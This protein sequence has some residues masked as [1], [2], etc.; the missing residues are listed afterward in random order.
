M[1]KNKNLHNAK[2]VKQ[3]EFYTQLS[4]IEKEMNSYIDYNPN[5]FKNKTILLPC[6]SPDT[7]NFTKFFI[8][9]FIELGIK[10]L[11]STS[12][13]PKSNIDKQINQQENILSNDKNDNTNYPNRGKVLILDKNNIHNDTKINI[14]NFSWNYL[15]GDGDFRS[16][17]VTSFRNN[18]DMVIT[19]PPFSL[20]REFVTWLIEGTVEFSIIGTMNAI[21][22][23][24]VFPLIRENKMWLGLSGIKSVTYEVPIIG[25]CEKPQFERNGKRYQSL[26]NTCWFSNICHGGINEPLQLMTMSENLQHNKQI[27]KNLNSYKKYDNY[28]AIEVPVVSGIPSDYDGVMGVPISFMDK[29][30]PEQFEIIGIAKRGAG[31]IS[32]RTRTYTKQDYKNYSDLNAGPVI[33]VDDI[34]KSIYPRILI[35]HKRDS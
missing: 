2:K 32:L 5:V 20:F 22:Y 14:E 19:N 35:R 6:D 34:P 25:D 17:E 26:R 3:D 23:K 31:D 13:A 16:E 24:E 33:I 8:E 18:A 28:D 10:K 21:T 15:K 12:Y 27:I 9:H 30:N 29:Y 7:S 1:T 11:I 4:D